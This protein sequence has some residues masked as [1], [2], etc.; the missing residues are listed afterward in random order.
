MIS[1]Y[2]NLEMLSKQLQKLL[3]V[4]GGDAQLPTRVV[5]L[6]AV[7][8][9][10]AYAEALKL[11]TGKHFGK[12]LAK[13]HWEAA[14]AHGQKMLRP[15]FQGSGFRAALLD[16]LYNVAGEFGDPRIIDADYLHNITRSSITDGLTGL[17]NQTYFKKVV[18]G[19]IVN[20][21]RSGDQ[22]FALVLFDLDH[23][24]HYND[25]CGH[26]AGDEALRQC[27]EIIANGLRDGDIAA[28]YGGE[29]FAL[30][31]P[32]IGRHDA[33]A[34]AERIRKS[35]ARHHFPKQELLNSHNLT[36]S[37]G[38]SIFPDNGETMA[39]VINAADKDL[40]KAKERRNCIYSPSEDRRKKARKPVKSLVEYASLD[41]SLFRPAL[42]FDIS[43]EGMGI[44]CENLL[45][46]GTVLSLRL[47]KPYWPENLI[48]NA[49]VRQVRQQ[50]DMVFV[51]LE[52][53]RSLESMKVVFPQGVANSTKGS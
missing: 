48:L 51:G 14:I 1:L 24:K 19:C 42:S 25:R 23:F 3:N 31:L 32:G 15:E 10:A 29:E 2:P 45:A 18:E 9:N 16:Y 41:G 38:I 26:L 8:G 37:G 53:D 6:A 52:F 4:S 12:E 39:E 33:F 20:Q 22:S 44:S 27:A 47:T 49:T 43:E 5:E 7:H 36:I 46:T 50:D 40:Y 35:I 13:T 34:V 30:F 21:R 11:I 28:R 17:Y